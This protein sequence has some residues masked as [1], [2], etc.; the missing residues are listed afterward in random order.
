MTL[1]TRRTIAPELMDDPQADRA[2]L[3]AALRFLSF[4]N[5]RLGGVAAVL[6]AFRRWAVDWP[7]GETMRILDLGTGYGDIPLALADWAGR[8]ARRV[9]ITALDRHETILSLTRQRI[10]ERADIELRL[11]DVLHLTDLFDVDSF[12]YAHAGLLLHQLPDIE[13][14]TVMRMMQR[15][16]RRGLIISDIVRSPI[17]RLGMYPWLPFMPP[18]VRH[19]AQ[20]SVAAAFTKREI[21]DLARR[22]GLERIRC[23]RHLLYRFTLTSE[24]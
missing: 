12:D 3:A 20:V 8:A 16:S 4:I 9:H 7:A 1:P 23:R 13:V 2:E 19:D 24:K 14:M 5:R 22:V 15:V 10:G 6:R 18:M 21:L 11:G 17:A